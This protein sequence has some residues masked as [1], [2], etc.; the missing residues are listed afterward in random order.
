M[1]RFVCLEATW[2]QWCIISVYLLTTVRKKNK[3]LVSFLFL[4]VLNHSEMLRMKSP[5]QSDSYPLAFLFNILKLLP[6]S[7][8]WSK[9]NPSLLLLNKL[10][11]LIQNFR[12]GIH[13]YYYSIVIFFNKSLFHLGVLWRCF[14]Q[15]SR[16]RQSVF[17]VGW[18]L[19]QNTH[20]Q[21]HCYFLLKYWHTNCTD[22]N[23][24]F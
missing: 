9:K 2:L 17:P 11:I 3:S 13:C 10:T 5:L 18:P 6:S 21:F 8:T 4:I 12:K 1:W 24:C 19:K 14:E 7:V 15:V 23:I 22:A 20:W 16:L